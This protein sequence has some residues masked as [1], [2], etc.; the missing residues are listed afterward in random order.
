M[1]K[2]TKKLLACIMLI[3]VLISFVSVHV[4][5]LKVSETVDICDYSNDIKFSI[6]YTD[7]GNTLY[8]G[9]SNASVSVFDTSNSAYLIASSGIYGSLGYDKYFQTNEA[10][11]TIGYPWKAETLIEID[12]SDFDI[13]DSD[14]SYLTFSMA[15]GVPFTNA[16]WTSSVLYCQKASGAY[17]TYAGTQYTSQQEGY[18]YAVFTVDKFDFTGVTTLTIRNLYES[19]GIPSSGS[20]AI[21]GK[22]S[23]ALSSF[24]F[25]SSVEDSTAIAKELEETMRKSAEQNHQDLNKIDQSIKDGNEEQHRDLTDIKDILDDQHEDEYNSALDKMDGKADD[26]QQAVAGALNID[27]FKESMSNLYNALTYSGTDSIWTFPAAHNIPF[28]GDLWD[29]Q[30]INMTYWIDNMPVAILYVIRFL[31]VFGV[32]WLIIAEIKGLLKF[33]TKGDDE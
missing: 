24:Y 17:V 30:Q 6:S 4:S 8:V 11:S 33:F 22:C 5:A 13:L 12:C 2:Q 10:V 26:N 23:F 27:G 28:I 31:F 20:T 7:V 25:T 15:L 21:E 14:S 29:E 18:V 19:G 16:S 1:E 3:I 9:L 32:V